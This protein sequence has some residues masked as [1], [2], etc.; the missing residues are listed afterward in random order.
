MEQQWAIL[1]TG[2]KRG[3]F[4][5]GVRFCPLI[6]HVCRFIRKICNVFFDV[7][8]LDAPLQ[9]GAHHGVVF[10][11]TVGTEAAG[12]LESVVVFQITGGQF[13]DRNASEIKVRADMG[14]QNSVGNTSTVVYVNDESEI[15]KFYYVSPPDETFWQ[16]ESTDI[17]VEKA[18]VDGYDADILI[19][20]D[21][22]VGNTIVW[23][24]SDDAGFCISGFFTAEDLIRLAESVCEK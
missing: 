4:L 7:P 16:V 24:T 5:N 9:R 10:N 12:N 14:V 20:E 2:K 11:D 6:A 19:S 21:A 23:M 15:L 8:V 22:A 18:T 1:R 13:A 3:D 17:T